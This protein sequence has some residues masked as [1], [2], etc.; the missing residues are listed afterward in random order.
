MVDSARDLSNARV[1]VVG[2]G[3]AG[4]YAAHAI[5]GAGAGISIDVFDRLPTPYGLVRYGVAPD[6]QKI[7]SVTRVLRAAFD[8]QNHVR[9]IGNVRFGTDIGRTDLLDHYDAVVYATGAQGDRRL[10]IPG[11]DLPGSYAAKEFVDWYGGHPDAADRSFSLHAPHA[12]VI[13]AGNVALD[14]ARM[15]VR[16][17]R[18]IATTDVPDRVLA[19][20]QG[21][22]VTD[23]HVIARRGVAQA[24]FTS[25]ELRAINELVDVDIVVRADE[26]SVTPGD[27]ERMAANRQ[28]R[29]N[30]EMF[31]DWASRPLSGKPRRMHVRFL[32]RP[33]RILGEKCVEGIQLERND[34]VPDGTVRGRREYETLKVEVIFRS[35]GYQPLPLPEVPFDAE[36]SIIP[37][38]EGRIVDRTG[39]LAGR[40]Y[41]TGWAKRGPTGII[42]TNKS[43]SAETVGNL[44]ADLASRASFKGGNGEAILTLLEDRGVDY[45]NWASWLRLDEHEVELGRRQGRPRVKLSSLASMMEICRGAVD[46]DPLSEEG[47]ACPRHR[48]Q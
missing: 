20:F 7:K 39:Q 3:P 34:L 43:D 32:R 25:E 23:V 33:I 27:E 46:P 36:R 4:L 6:N 29:A 17:P 24:K 38:R 22:R 31:R 8:D 16:S 14:I 35:L 10:G 28:L 19:A 42:G 15:L 21:T 44:L 45:T 13:G 47:H 12:A 41:V 1:A 30:V 11:E 2:A 9:F 18:E 26:L 48:K 5:L 37:H 40:E